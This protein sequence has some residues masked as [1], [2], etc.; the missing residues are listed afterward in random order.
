M[1]VFLLCFRVQPLRGQDPRPEGTADE[2]Q[3]GLWHHDAKEQPKERLLHQVSHEIEKAALAAELAH[4]PGL[5]SQV[6][7]SFLQHRMKDLGVL[8]SNAAF[9]GKTR[10]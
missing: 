6:K 9:G 2:Q 1:L 8:Q 10:K 5:S 3:H 7:A 4:R